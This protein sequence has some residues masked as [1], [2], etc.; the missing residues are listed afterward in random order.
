MLLAVNESKE[1]HTQPRDEAY[2]RFDSAVSEES[3]FS[4]G[5]LLW[6]S[7]PHW[8]GTFFMTIVL[9]A[10]VMGLACLSCHVTRQDQELN[11]ANFPGAGIVVRSELI[12]LWLPETLIDLAQRQSQSRVVRTHGELQRF[13]EL[14]DRKDLW[15]AITTRGHQV[16]GNF[17]DI[18]VIRRP[19]ADPFD[20]A[21]FLDVLATVT[22]NPPVDP[23]TD[24]S[25][26]SVHILAEGL[27]KCDPREV[28]AELLA[29]TSA[30]PAQERSP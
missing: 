16:N 18:T 3:I 17:V 23:G 2:A 26:V 11:P 22:G 25:Q 27:L 9:A 5:P 20:F 29:H 19:Y 30:T 13:L 4:S 8:G 1:R 21:E 10:G 14:E 24:S 12:R 28:M 7:L 15:Y 6:Q